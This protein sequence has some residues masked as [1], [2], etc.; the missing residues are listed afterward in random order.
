MGADAR[1]KKR[2]DDRADG[3]GNFEEHA[4]ADVGEALAHVGCRRTGRRGDDGDERCADG[5]FDVDAER[6]RER[7]NHDHAAAKTGERAEKSGEGGESPD[8][9]CE[10]QAVIRWIRFFPAGTLNVHVDV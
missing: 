8:D 3:R 2:A 6:Q 9:D 10:F 4:D 7:R 1:G 5:V